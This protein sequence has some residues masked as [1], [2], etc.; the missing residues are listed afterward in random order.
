M[1]TLFAR[2]GQSLSSHLRNVDHQMMQVL[3]RVPVR[4]QPLEDESI[5][6]RET[7]ELTLRAIAYCHD[8]GKCSSFF[9]DRLVMGKTASGD[10]KLSY[11]VEVS[12][13]LTYLAIHNLFNR[14][15]SSGL[16]DQL[17]TAGCLVV[18]NHHF[19]I[20]EGDP[21][22]VLGE[23]S[24]P[25]IV[26]IVQ[27]IREQMHKTTSRKCYQD[28]IPLRI[29]DA[30]SASM[31][32]LFQL[33]AEGVLLLLDEIMEIRDTVSESVDLFLLTMF[34]YSCLCDAD[35]Y[36]AKFHIGDQQAHFYP[37]DEPR[38]Q[39][40]STLIDTYR[41]QCLT[42]GTWA[43]QSIRPEIAAL[44]NATYDKVS[45][46]ASSAQ[47]G[48][49]YTIT[50]PTGSGKTLALLNFGIRLRS[51]YEKKHGYRPKV[52]YSLPFVSIA[53]QVGGQIAA[54]LG[55]EDSSQQDPQLT[56]HHH[57]VEPKWNPL[58]PQIPPI[59]DKS[60]ASF[61]VSLW[62]SDFTVTSFVKL[63]D[64]ILSAN[65]RNLLRLNRIAGSVLLLDEVQGI[66]VKYWDIVAE[67][68][69]ILARDYGCSIVLSTAT[70]PRILADVYTTD[71]RIDQ[72]EFG[73]ARYFMQC[74][75]EHMSIDAFQQRLNEYIASHPTEN[76]VVV[77]NTKRSAYT[78]F[79]EVMK[80]HPR[81]EVYFMSGLVTPHDRMRTLHAV[82]HILK[83][84]ERRCILVCTQLIEAGVDV[85][86]DTVFRDFAPLD[87]LIQ[88]AGR[89]NRHSEHHEQRPVFVFHLFEDGRELACLAYNDPVALSTTQEVLSE[90][91]ASNRVSGLS[92]DSI[93]VLCDSYYNLLAQ[94]KRTSDC[95]TPVLHMNF[96]RL[97]VE[98]SLIDEIKDS[99][100]VF[101]KNADSS[102]TYEEFK[103]VLSSRPGQPIRIPSRFYQFMVMP[104]R[105]QAY[106]FDLLE[107]VVVNGE[108]IFFVLDC[109]KH[110]KMYDAS[111]GLRMSD[112]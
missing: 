1:A 37:A 80:V 19:G 58:Q 60:V 70:Q 54:I 69:N 91:I 27:D 26:T 49:I 35:E 10:P 96:R 3:Q 84:R 56:V 40:E 78:V 65:K 99:L 110:P 6:S 106:D 77:L 21:A 28:T 88:I 64:S 75:E 81:G 53:D 18:M 15:M 108:V 23:D 98:F 68:L 105:G 51:E 46:T 44:R 104:T 11:H 41:Q 38:S 103:Q 111:S 79:N 4:Y 16:L 95:M 7:I 24:L 34:M 8:F 109:G 83:K 82:R 93:G 52:I 89:C 42:D 31:D 61:F 29:R 67:V 50:A 25:R 74:N 73:I 71:T 33:D 92:E 14:K 85:S 101:I 36:D 22:E 2:P 112:S 102:V 55:K 12:A 17:K 86:F 107:P 43:P 20:L 45:R 97:S 72:G 13:L 59:Q 87:S 32:H 76:I 57:L 39:Y 100:T 9:Q 63:W 62:R 90:S 66:P 94:R 47:P 30:V 5:E 48:S